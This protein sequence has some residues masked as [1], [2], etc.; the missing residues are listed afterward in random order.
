VLGLGDHQI[1]NV[2]TMLRHVTARTFLIPSIS[3]RL[4]LRH[5]SSISIRL[6]GLPLM[7]RQC[8]IVMVLIGLR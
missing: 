6:T 2:S 8:P 7:Y 1:T 3:S 5:S 4:K